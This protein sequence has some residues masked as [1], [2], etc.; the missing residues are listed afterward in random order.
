MMSKIRILQAIV[1]GLTYLLALLTKVVV[2]QK[3]RPH[4]QKS[5]EEEEN[6]RF[7]LSWRVAVEANNVCP[8]RT[9][10]PRCYHH[11]QN[12]MC[13]GQYERDLNL[14]V[15]HIL[16]YASQIQLSSDGMDA[17]ILDVDDTCISNVSYYKAKRFGCEPFDSTIFKAW[18]MKGMCPANP[19]VRLLFNTLK[20]RGFKLFLLTGRDQA[21]LSAITTHNLHTQGF[22]G[23]QRLILRSPEYKGQGAVK[24]KSAIRKEIEREGYRIWGNVGDQWSD[25]QGECSGKR[26]FKLPNPMYFIS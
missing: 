7:G 14:V 9:V 5:A 23:Y 16:I 21:T 11:L 12:Y 1:A 22:V 4:Q 2:S 17:W 13:A 3:G 25:L 20:E 26:T 24:Y 19:A 8:W 10:P 15:E 18:I 6:E